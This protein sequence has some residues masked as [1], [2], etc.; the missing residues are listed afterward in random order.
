MLVVRN[1][2]HP[3]Q[4]W[5]CRKLLFITKLTPESDQFVTST[6]FALQTKPSLQLICQRIGYSSPFPLFSSM[7]C[8]DYHGYLFKFLPTESYTTSSLALLNFF[9]LR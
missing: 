7:L 9:W 6:S 3:F 8:A 1:K 4:R 2:L 5:N